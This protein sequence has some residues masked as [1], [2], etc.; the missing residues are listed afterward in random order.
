VL[1]S[2]DLRA[3]VNNLTEV[4]K[5]TPVVLG[6]DQCMEEEGKRRGRNRG[7]R[8]VEGMGEVEIRDESSSC[9]GYT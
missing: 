5:K 1:R 2:V 6:T 9:D 4:K 8:K 7:C 3:G